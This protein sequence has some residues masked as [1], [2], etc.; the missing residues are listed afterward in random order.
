MHTYILLWRTKQR[1]KPRIRFTPFKVILKDVLIS[2]QQTFTADCWRPICRIY[3]CDV[4]LSWENLREESVGVT[5]P[6]FYII[7]ISPNQTF[8]FDCYLNKA[9]VSNMCFA[10][11]KIFLLL[12]SVLSIW[13]T[14]WVIWI[15]EN[16][17]EMIILTSWN[18]AVYTRLSF[19]K[20]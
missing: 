1:W 17:S 4:L 20:M 6:T 15:Q 9:W 5:F 11:K 2:P 13:V 3:C 7:Y 14:W 10:L 8:T 19:D 18:S 16:L 12:S